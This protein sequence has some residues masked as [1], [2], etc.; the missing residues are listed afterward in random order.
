MSTLMVVLAL[1]GQ[2]NWRDY[3]DFPKDRLP[4]PSSHFTYQKVIVYVE[5][6]FDSSKYVGEVK[7]WSRIAKMTFWERFG[8]LGF[9]SMTLFIIKDIALL[10]KRKNGRKR[11]GRSKN[12]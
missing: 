2:A 3:F 11:N 7:G 5:I 6:P 1:F 8:A 12:T 4:P 10:L 9:G